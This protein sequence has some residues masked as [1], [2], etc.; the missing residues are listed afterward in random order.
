M[1]VT[2]EDFAVHPVDNCL[3]VRVGGGEKERER[4]EEGW[5]EKLQRARTVRNR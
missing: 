3:R 2:S 4:V 5:R 1:R